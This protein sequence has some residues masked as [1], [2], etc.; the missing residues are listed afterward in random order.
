MYSLMGGESHN[1]GAARCIQRAMKA[2][3]RAVEARDLAALTNL[4]APDVVFHSPV[5][6]QAYR[7]REQVGF[8]LA[9]FA[10]VCEDFV[11]VAE[12]ETGSHS[13][14][15]FKGRVGE[16]RIDG[17]DLIEQDAEGRVARLTVL[18]RPLS[19]LQALAEAMRARLAPQT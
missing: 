4:L 9:T 17:V 10:Q 1:P 3:R 16:R 2:F 12:M 6:F 18:V 14:L 11:Y 8:V 7:G 5:T 19:G 15:V 13:A